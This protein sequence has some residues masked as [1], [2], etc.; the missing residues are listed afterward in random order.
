MTLIASKGWGL[1]S[2]EWFFLSQCSGGS[3]SN[4]ETQKNLIVRMLLCKKSAW[5]L[6]PHNDI[7]DTSLAQSLQGRQWPN[8]SLMRDKLKLN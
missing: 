3:L 2:R 6:I 5:C 7:N 8:M 1:Q 4:E